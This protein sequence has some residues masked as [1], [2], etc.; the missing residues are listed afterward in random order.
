MSDRKIKKRY[1]RK[2]G[3]DRTEATGGLLAGS[4]G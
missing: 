1:T 4:A 3:C 2:Q